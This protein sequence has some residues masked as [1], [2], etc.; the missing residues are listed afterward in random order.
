M[1]K[2]NIFNSILAL[3][4]LVLVGMISYKIITYK[5]WDRYYYI[6]SVSVPQE[7]PIHILGIWFYMPDG[8]FGNG[9]YKDKDKINGFY[10]DWGLGEYYNAYE[11]ELLPQRLFVEYVDFR[12]RQ[13][14]MDTIP[15][16]KERMVTVFEDA[17]MHNHL[18]NLHYMKTNMGLE[19]HVG[20]A[21][22]GNIIFWLKGDKYE[23][24]FYRVQLKPKAFP[25][26]V[27]SYP[28]TQVILDK[29][30]YIDD[31][32]QQVPDSIKH[33][34]MNLDV[35]NIQYKDSIPVYFYSKDQ[36]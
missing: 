35:K 6:S 9:F 16:P 23:R 31:L 26:R 13:Y 28:D 20:I 27:L 36:K 5:A 24:E 11:P 4:A 3:I 19:F 34:I 1:K 30:K 14:Y 2:L 15:L 8:S 25:D 17:K 7:F 10:S 22:E 32:F 29:E 33:E 18:D 12:T 21:N